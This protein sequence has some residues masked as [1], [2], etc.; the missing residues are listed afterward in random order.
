MLLAAADNQFPLSLLAPIVFGALLA[1]AILTTRGERRDGREDSLLN[2]LEL[3]GWLLAVCGSLAFLLL[4]VGFRLLIPI[5]IAYVVALVVVQ[6]FRDSE[7]RALISTLTI[8]AERG[9]PLG[10]A[11][12]AFSGERRFA[13]SHRMQ[14]LADLLEAGV[15][16]DDAMARARIC[17]P[18]EMSLAVRVGSV[19]GN[20]GPVLRQAAG[21]AVTTDAL[22]VSV[23]EK[24]MYLLL[25][26]CIGLPIVFLGVLRILPTFE[27]MYQEFGAELPAITKTFVSGVNTLSGAGAL[28]TLATIGLYTVLGICLLYYLRWLNTDLPLLRRLWL[29]LDRSI[30]LRVLATWTRRQQSIASALRVLQV[31]YPKHSIRRRLDQAVESVDAGGDWCRALQA[32]GLINTREAALLEAAERVGNLGWALDEIAERALQRTVQRF[33][34]AL[35]TVFPFIVLAIGALVLLVVA[36]EIVPLA[37]MIQWNT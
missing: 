33:Q 13:R 15:P 23:L 16:L 9:I 12:R 4:V 8:A 7:Q 27:E 30:L 6:R 25:V 24:L 1:W 14:N 20:L 31:Q 36:A 29:P 35:D 32:A 17:L 26:L 34:R 18:T 28:L 2:I 37:R 11:A 3:S 10:Q 19:A 5:A 22:M 21:L